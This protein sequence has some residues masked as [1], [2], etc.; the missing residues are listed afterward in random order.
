[1]PNLKEHLFIS[2]AATGIT[3]LAMSRYYLR[4]PSLEEA[5]TCV[6]VG[7]L[8]GIAPDLMEPA[9]H[10]QHRQFCHSLTAGGLL[11]HTGLTKC[12]EQNNNWSQFAKILGACVII[13]YLVHLALDAT[14]PRSL[15]LLG[16]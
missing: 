4:Q 5:V 6:G 1:M 2:A 11:V 16:K 10:P 7:M 15:P 3:Y 13:G 9:L 8:S 12:G 14:T